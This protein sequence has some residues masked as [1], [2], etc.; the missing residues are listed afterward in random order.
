[1]PNY[2]LY[3]ATLY[4]YNTLHVYSLCI[5]SIYSMY[6]SHCMLLTS[7][8]SQIFASGEPINKSYKFIIYI[9]LQVVF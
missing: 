5:I 9:S 7:S 6:N 8:I 2:N 3:I 4:V 1:M